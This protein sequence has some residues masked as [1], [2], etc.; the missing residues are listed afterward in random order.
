MNASAGQQEPD[1]VTVAVDTA[2]A[3]AALAKV[4]AKLDEIGR[5]AAHVAADIHNGLIAGLDKFWY[6]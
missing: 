3:E 4:G 2:A 6:G 1:Q 5:K